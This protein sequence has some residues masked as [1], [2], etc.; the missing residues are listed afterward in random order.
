MKRL[1]YGA[2]LFKLVVDFDPV[3]D[4]ALIAGHEIPEPLR[5]ELKHAASN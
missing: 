1:K 4:N 3:I 5:K 2:A